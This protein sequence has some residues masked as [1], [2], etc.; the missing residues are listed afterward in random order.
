MAWMVAAGEAA[1]LGWPEISP[2]HLWLGLLKV[3]DVPPEAVQRHLGLAAA[4]VAQAEREL[5][6][7]E[8]TWSLAGIEPT[9]ARRHLR[10]L[11]GVGP[12]V[13]ADQSFHRTD[14]S[15]R[16]FRDAEHLRQQVGHPQVDPRHLLAV[17]GRQLTSPV[18]KLWQDLPVDRERFQKAIE[19]SL[20]A[21]P[22]TLPRGAPTQPVPGAE[23]VRWGRDLTALARAGKL[24]PVV[25]RGIEIKKLA[26]VLSQKRKNNVLLVGDAGVGKSCIVEGF[27]QRLAQHSFP[28]ELERARVVELSLTSLL[29][30]T[31]YRGEFEA[32]LEHVLQEA[33]QDESLILFVDEIH[34]LV[35][36][37]AAEGAPLDA[38]NIFKPALARGE[39]RLIG[40]TTTPEYQRWI[41]RDSAL[42]RRFQVIWVEE[43]TAEETLEML[44]ELR[45]TF[46]E[47]HQVN[48]PDEVLACAIEL[49]QRYLSDQRL[50]DKALDAIDQACA[51]LRFR[52]SQLVTGGGSTAPLRLT[53]QDVALVI[54]AR[55]R[56]PV[57][58][59]LRP[60]AGILQ[61]LEAH[62]DERVVGQPAAVAA[63]ADGIRRARARLKVPHRPDAVWLFAG[64]TGVG[65]TELARTLAD[66]LYPGGASSLIYFDM[67]EYAES[68]ALAKL[69][70]APP[71]YVGFGAGGQ[72]VNQVRRQPYAV[73]LFDE[74]EKAHPD[75]L[76]LFLQICDEGR[77]TDS[78]G[79]RADFTNTVVIFT[80][81]LGQERL[82]RGKKPIGF[83][84]PAASS[85][86]DDRQ[87][88]ADTILDGVRRHLRPELFNRLDQ[89]VVFYPLTRENLERILDK[90]LA[91]L[92]ASDP[93][94]ALSLEV[95]AAARE[96][97]LERGY[98]PSL[99]ARALRRALEQLLAAP[100]S[101]WLLAHP[102]GPAGRV[103]VSRVGDTLTFQ[104]V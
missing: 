79:Q 31:K 14:D 35:G 47:H 101:R 70:G 93:A 49:T 27:A 96:L 33:A 100:L 104:P 85:A 54:A 103:R 52:S 55:T 57:D 45:P 20:Q 23:L 78:V 69:V 87:R 44:R 53:P 81:N 40:A 65:K 37:G 88:Y 5:R 39:L 63:V 6:D 77:L 92:E 21:T 99:G 2:D 86:A 19:Q 90:F 11:L 46:E 25:G 43:P 16:V 26:R 29:A 13:P 9:T 60:R 84:A 59:L 61:D 7:L 38:A 64:A 56:L 74:V 17:L 51:S 18:A 42:S 34:H 48:I 22:G 75:V 67:S 66:L 76:N 8:Q 102:G 73:V 28:G 83:A 91:E 41:E 62:L 97:L 36:A 30:G 1:N 15:R 82:L 10:A 4:A 72:L 71:G 98:D 58:K 24:S 3:V 94:R 80:S 12:G 50:P 95:E 32:R 89:V 68:H